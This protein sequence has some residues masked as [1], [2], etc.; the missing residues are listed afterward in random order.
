MAKLFEKLCQRNCLHD[1]W[2][3]VRT[4]NSSGGIDGMSVSDFDQK[5]NEHIAELSAVLRSGKWM[6]HPYKGITIPKNQKE[7]RNIGLLSIKDKIV[8]TAI[9]LLVEPKFE[10]IF[11]NN[12]YGYRP[13]KGHNKAVKRTLFECQNNQRNWFV[14]LDID[15]YFDTI[16]HDILSRNL[17]SFVKDEEIV[18]L[19][20]LCMKMGRVNSK[21]KWQDIT[22]GV[23]QG[24]VLSPLLSNFYL[25]PFDKFVAGQ[26]VPYVR[27]ADDFVIIC[28][29]REQA[30][31]L[32][33]Q[34]TGFLTENLS[35]SLNQPIIGELTTGFDFLGVNISKSGIGL[36][37]RKR[38]DIKAKI[39]KFD[40]SSDGLNLH[41]QKTWA[42]FHTYYKALLS[43][44]LL[45]GLDELLHIKLKSII[46]KRYK[47]F[48]NQ[49]VLK[50]ILEQIEF[51]SDEYGRNKKK[52]IR[53][54]ITLYASQ[55]SGSREAEAEKQNEKIIS[56]RKREYQKRENENRELVVNTNGSTI[57]LTKKGVTVKQQGKIIYQ[58]PVGSLSHITISGYGITLS[59]HLIDYCLANKISI[60]FF[61]PYGVHTGSILSNKYIESTYW[62]D[63]ACCG[64]RKRRILAKQIIM[65]KL[66]NQ[67]NLVKYFHKYHKHNNP[68]LSE[69]YESVSEFY[70]SF[71]SFFKT[72][73]VEEED[74]LT[75][76]V[77][78]EAQGALKYWEYIRML[79]SDDKIEFEKREHKGAKDIVNCMLNYG[80]ALLYSRVWQALLKAKL[81]PFDSIIHA[82][83]SG[84]PTFVYDVVEIFRA[85]VVDR[86]V[87]SLVQ[88]GN[89]LSVKNGMLDDETKKLLATS[90]LERLNRYETYRGDEIT[91][92]Q[93]INRQTKEIAT[94]ILEVSTPYKPY[95]AKW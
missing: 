86:V 55:K 4:K 48:P 42:G 92:E 8:Q 16:R 68:E 6:P 85:Q 34:A 58:K 39:D 38:E 93:I 40:L 45:S 63:Q 82:R 36:S 9:K 90:V 87:I 37:E 2:Y 77:A 88:K 61:S 80:Y 27:Y 49:S 74:F 71:H 1:A 19:I 75:L 79:F 5:A 46:E 91:M 76:L 28:D 32:L 66:K 3:F 30:E 70:D 59:S 22:A 20:M 83:Q 29:S 51:L 43:Q 67:F 73:D 95:I 25:H 17:Y 89:A 64:V 23:P 12:S 10:R 52:I 84:K 33:K 15:D 81:N 72:K 47:A 18:R 60:D 78:Y 7:R 13:G 41:G 11:L 50:Q 62:N 53:D 31:S 14:K 56:K 26:S 65:G 35:L 57:G 54:L 94:F 21:M 44:H 24:A 69:M